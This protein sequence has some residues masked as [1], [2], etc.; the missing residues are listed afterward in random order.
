MNSVLAL[1]TWFNP[2]TLVKKIES[3]PSI[4][5]PDMDPKFGTHPLM[6]QER[7]VQ[8]EKAL[9]EDELRKLLK[10]RP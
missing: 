6:S 5:F 1:G 4:W 2:A 7:L 3:F 10:R 8:Q 9:S